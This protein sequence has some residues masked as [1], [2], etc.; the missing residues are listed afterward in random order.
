MSAWEGK[1][2]IGITGNIATGKSV[3]RKMLEHLGAQGIDA[4]RLAHRAIAKGAPGYEP[5]INAFG[6]WIL[7][8]DGEIER[9]KLG[10]LVFADADALASLEEI[11]HPLVR[12]AIEVLIRRSR[13]RVIAIEAIK[14]YE[15]SLSSMC[16]SIWVT[17]APR[18]LQVERLM[19]KRSLTQQDAALRID[20]QPPQE[21][22]V[23]AADLLIR[24]DGG[25]ETTWDKVLEAWEAIVPLVETGD[26]ATEKDEEPPAEPA[27][28][29]LVVERARPSQAKELAE[30]I[31]RLSNGSML[32]TRGDVMAA[33]GEKAFLVLQS[34]GGPVGLLGWQVENLV[35]RTTDVL[36]KDDVP[37]D[38]SMETL[39]GEVER[40]AKDLQCEASLLFLPEKMAADEK[41]WADLGY[42]ASSV[43]DLGVR[44]WQ[45]AAR[46]SMPEQTVLFFK[47]LREDR[48]LRP[49]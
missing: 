48:V 43:D 34:N 45:E 8:P 16:D 47:R 40:A 18:E 36:L 6:Q 14:L 17:W 42:Q 30:L 10:R 24:N 28:D 39:M 15:S 38:S 21:E 32:M 2:V 12:Q 37:L 11:V 3:V 31:N 19:E 25:F 26:L 22:K 29:D 35:A 33:F 49:V 5:V 46:E 41:I 9:P 20:A 1:Y 4:D 13:R 27:P 7:G 23:A 44:A